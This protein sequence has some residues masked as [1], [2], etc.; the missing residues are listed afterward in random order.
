MPSLLRPISA[1]VVCGLFLSHVHAQTPPAEPPA[2]PGA[3]EKPQPEK[4]KDAKPEPKKEVIEVTGSGYDERKDDTA[5]KIVVNSAEI[6]KYG[7]T[8]VLDVLKRLPGVTVT[9]N[10]IRMRGLSQGYTQILVDG[11]RPPPGFSLENL[12]PALIERIEVVRAA[13][14]EFSTQSIAGTINIVL[15]SKVSFAQRDLRLNYS[16]GS[17]FRSPNVN[18]VMSDKVDNLGYTVSGSVY[19]NRI[20]FE[21]VSEETAVDAAGRRTLFRQAANTSS[22]NGEGFNVAPRL[23]WTMKGG[24]SINWQGFFN[25]NRGDGRGDFGYSTTEGAGVPV[26]RN[27]SVYD[28]DNRYLR[29]DLNIVKKLAD[30]AKLEA[31]LVVS[32]S[33]FTNDSV[34]RGFNAANQQNLDRVSRTR[35]AERSFGTSGKLS[36]AW[37]EGHSIVTGWDFSRTPREQT[38]FQND[39]PIPNVQPAVQAFNADERFEATVDKAAVFA[40]DEWNVTKAWSIYLGLRWEGIR[41]TS[42]GSGFDG[43]RSTSSVWSPIMQTLYKLQSR[44]GEQVRLALTRTYKAPDTMRLIPR[45]FSSIDNRPTSPDSTGN[46]A[47]KPELATGVDIAYEKFWGQGSSMSLAGS[48]RRITDYNRQG[49]RFIDGR[50]VSLPVNDGKANTRSL[51]FD[52][53]FPVQSVWKE[54]PPVDFR[55]N[56]NKNWS[57]VDSVPGPNNRLDQQIPFSA[58]LGLDYRMRGGMIT[59]GGSFSYKQGGDVRISANQSLFQTA[60]RDLDLYGLWKI[61]PKTQVRLTLANILTPDSRD[62]RAYFDESG[63]TRTLR[64][65]PSKM[66]IRAGLEIKL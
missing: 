25:F 65:S 4:A 43:A 6:M 53:K 15:K 49:L 62:E 11:E 56:M 46:P 57:S 50:W 13:T 2:K 12:S 14:A 26:N 32:E 36:K 23:V 35:S 39:T 24:D 18:F 55:F 34:V 30:G 63:S 5:T 54:A 51:E 20:R 21:N 22:G 52:T 40:Q 31:K 64:V 66:T 7:D 44:P 16:Q 60:K 10:A 48:L 38:N 28:Y 9:G 58:T 19:T 8:Q 29:S 27:E 61:T 45:R 33:S 37:V 41:T 47:L 1:L 17:F 42:E 59:A 3:T